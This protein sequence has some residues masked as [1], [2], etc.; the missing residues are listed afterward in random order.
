[1][2]WMETLQMNLGFEITRVQLLFSRR[3]DVYLITAVMPDK[4]TNNYV[5]KVKA[6]PTANEEA[7]LLRMLGNSGIGVPQVLWNDARIILLEYLNGVLL[8]DLVQVAQ[9]APGDDNWVEALA[10]WLWCLHSFMRIGQGFCLCMPDLN[11]RNFIYKDGRFFGFDFEELVFARPER[12]LGGLCA[13]ILN[14]DPMFAAYKYGLVKKLM[15]FYIC[16]G[17]KSN[18][19]SG[20][21]IDLDLVYQYYVREMDAAVK[22]RKKQK[23]NS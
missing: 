22:R 14:N 4:T 23:L 7:L 21:S 17:M 12:D 20:G 18:S 5:V 19:L 11:L 13:Y 9:T 10:K 1:M 16:L 3:N 2:E 6:R 15:L 8:T